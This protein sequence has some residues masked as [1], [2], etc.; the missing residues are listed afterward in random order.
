M[1][2]H[3]L[4]KASGYKFKTLGEHLN[5]QPYQISRLLQVGPN[6]IQTQMLDAV[7][8]GRLCICNRGE[9]MKAISRTKMMNDEKKMKLWDELMAQLELDRKEEASKKNKRS[10]K[11]GNEKPEKVRK[12]RTTNLVK[13]NPNVI[14]AG[15]RRRASKK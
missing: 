14:G 12:K 3:Q 13:K 7:L 9:L 15:S 10:T 11:N 6:K 4:V 2:L 5:L 8:V 1:N